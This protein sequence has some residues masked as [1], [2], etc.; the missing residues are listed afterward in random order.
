MRQNEFLEAY[1]KC[2]DAFVQY[3][4]TLACDKMDV[5][6][7]VQEAK[8]SAYRNFDKIEKGKLLDYLIRTA[9]DIWISQGQK[10]EH[11]PKKKKEDEFMKT[12]NKC[13]DK[14][15]RYCSALAYG[16][17]DSRD[18]VQ[19]ALSSAWENFDEIQ[20]GKLF[21]YMIKVAKYKY[22]GQLRKASYHEEYIRRHNQRL[23]DKGTLPEELTD[24]GFLY[25]AL[26]KLS[27]HQ[28][29]AI[30]LYDICGFSMKEI[31][32]IQNSKAGA[33]RTKIS[34]GR[35][36]LRALLLEE[37]TLEEKSFKKRNL[38]L[39][40]ITMKENNG[41]DLF[42]ILRDAPTELSKE[43]VEK[44]IRGFP[45][46]SPPTP[47]KD[48]G[49]EEG[50]KKLL[51][52]ISLNNFLFICSVIIVA[53]G[54]TFSP[55][56]EVP[57]RNNFLTALDLFSVN[58]LSVEHDE[59]GKKT[60]SEDT[61]AKYEEYAQKVFDPKK[62]NCANIVVKMLHEKQDVL[63]KPLRLPRINKNIPVLQSLILRQNIKRFDTIAIRKGSVTV[64]GEANVVSGV[65]TNKDYIFKS[66]EEALKIPNQVYILDLSD[67]DLYAM[68]EDIQ[69]F[70]NLEELYLSENHL[71]S[72]PEFIGDLL[73]LRKLY[74]DENE[75]TSIPKSIGQLSKLEE[76]QL[77]HN[78]LTSIPASISKLSNLRELLL[79]SNRLTSIPE[80]IGQLFNLNILSLKSNL[81]TKIP[82]SIGQLSSLKALYLNDNKLTKLPKAIGG[83]S[84]LTALNLEGNRFAR[85][86][87]CVGHL[88]KLT[89]LWLGR[90][91]LRGVPSAIGK[92]SNLK[93]FYLERNLLK[94]L[95]ITIGLLSNLEVLSLWENDL[96]Q[97]P[98]S[99]GQLSN[100][101]KL[102]L[103][104]NNLRYLPKSINQLTELRELE[105]SY[106]ELK[107]LPKFIGGLSSLEV[108][109]CVGNQVEILPESIGQLSALT[110]FRFSNNKLM[111][112]TE[113]IG[114]LSNLEFLD[115][116]HNRLREVPVTIGELSSLKKLRLYHNNLKKL[117]ESIGQLVNL[118]F[119]E[120]SYNRLREIPVTIGN[121][122]DLRELDLSHNKLVELP[123]S[124]IQLNDMIMLSL[125]YNR[126][127]KQQLKDI[128]E[129]LPNCEIKFTGKTGR[130]VRSNMQ[131][132]SCR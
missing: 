13:H 120:L 20:D 96:Y 46:V 59:K 95:P 118:E 40:I 84:S 82:S 98:H 52:K 127:K 41:N 99:V 30:I 23:I 75:L 105:L 132:L 102:Y 10:L 113:S 79:Y 42:K 12:Y 36:K 97:L 16:K 74:I 53:T 76:L 101:K 125:Y 67:H 17:M 115:L 119:L 92:L 87:K 7:L 58:L 48:A 54:F 47:D 81:L 26:N 114:Q 50:V 83:L 19:D 44:I 66:I 3:C 86:P 121:L 49:I 24:I 104:K 107:R 51:G 45:D 122:L 29:D 57:A 117:P 37:T 2:Y 108:L 43:E 72:I 109:S 73:H 28:R 111:E 32:E 85:F 1:N 6:Y 128:A 5:E 14:F 64:S 69:Q 71:F 61:L 70:V 38:S 88:T 91:N 22:F 100:L 124:I 103:T 9:R 21:N 4:S 35:E 129:V 62:R 15:I 80:S 25:Q 130:S 39:L 93:E 18:L 78:K 126:I 89:Y 112:I 63:I 123:S 31:A 55:I 8:L 77:C 90:N 65:P 94:K 56:E 27:E 110:E 33:V 68:P 116:S 131:T 11:E 106:N 60:L 34:R